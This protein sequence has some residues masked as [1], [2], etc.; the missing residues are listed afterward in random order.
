MKK[1][2][3]LKEA[4]K[5]H[6]IEYNYSLVPD[7][8]KKNEN[9][10]I[11]C[12]KHGLFTPRLSRFLKGSNCKYCSGKA[13]KTYEEFVKDARKVHEDIYDYSEFVYIG[14]HIPS[15]IICKKH[16]IFPCS[17][18]N[19]LNGYGCPECKKEK[20]HDLFVS[21]AEEFIEKAKKIH[22]DKYKYNEVNYQ[23][24]CVPV[25]I[26]CP[27]HGEFWQT[28]SNHLQGKGCKFC[29][30]SHLENELKLF[31]KD[32]NFLTEQEKHLKW[33]GLM[34]LDFYIPQYNIA[35]ECQGAQHLEENHFMESFETILA[36]DIKKFNLC[37]ENGIQLLYYTNIKFDKSN[38]C[39][40][41]IYTEENTFYDLD[42]LLTK[43]TCDKFYDN[44]QQKEE[45]K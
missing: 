26:I 41:G 1:E 15:N 38:P 10:P 35:I 31:L 27:I 5:M 33:L 40:E 45:Q 20:L 6:T 17:P 24:R 18:T 28:P 22:G 25:N 32:K 8:V 2:D 23:G 30:S 9:V 37:K 19:H 34:S 16:G 36:R 29:K 12:P 42:E 13:K 14:S 11:I 43:I 39:F 44:I 7:E 21:N 4:K 3:I